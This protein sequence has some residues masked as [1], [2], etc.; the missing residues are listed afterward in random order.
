VKIA[1]FTGGNPVFANR[2]ERLRI[3][4]L[5]KRRNTAVMPR[6][7]S[8]YLTKRIEKYNAVFYIGNK[9]TIDTYGEFQLPQAYRIINNGYIS[10]REINYT[11]K[12]N[13]NFLYFA[14]V[15]QVHKGLDL[16]LEIFGRE[17]CPYHLYICSLAENELDFCKV[18]ERELYH[19]D[20]IHLMGFIEPTSEEYYDI[21]DVCAYSLLPS[22]AEGIAGS[23]LTT[24]SEGVIPI[25]SK[26]CG[27]EEDEVIML[28]DCEID[29]IRQMIEQCA[30]KSSEWIKEQSKKT[31]NIIRERYSKEHFIKSVTEGLE[32]AL[33][34]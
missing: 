27:F 32:G 16:L 19:C 3:S 30:N 4:E 11:K 15:G 6:R 7:Q 18:Y 10:D 28:E 33:G 12:K 34:R 31:L 5:E 23:V 20:N 13:Y 2:A 9:F 22:S 14:S 8:P 21:V 26:M 17:D 1:Y 24:M 29:T 25:C